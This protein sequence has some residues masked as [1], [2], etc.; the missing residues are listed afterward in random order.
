MCLQP[1]FPNRHKSRAENKVIIYFFCENI[2]YIN[3]KV[4]NY[5]CMY[6]R[7]RENRMRNRNLGKNQK[8]AGVGFRARANMIGTA[9]LLVL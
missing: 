5:L 1:L 9:F 2:Y 8:V 3:Y 4:K 6:D 7:P